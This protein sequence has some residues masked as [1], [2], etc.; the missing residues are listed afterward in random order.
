MCHALADQVVEQVRSKVALL[1]LTI[2]NRHLPKLP[3][4]ITLKD[5][6][7]EVRTWN[8]LKAAGFARRP[9][10]LS[11]KCIGEILRI[12]NFGAKSLVDLLTSLEASTPKTQAVP[13]GEPEAPNDGNSG[14]NLIAEAKRL[15][16]TNHSRLIH[17]ND[18]RLGEMVRAIDYGSET[19]YE[20]ADRLLSGQRIP[21]SAASVIAQLKELQEKIRAV[22]RIKLEAELASVTSGAAGNGRN[23]DIVARYF[24]WD[25]LG[26]TTLQAIGSEVGL[27]RERVRQICG[28]VARAIVR[29]KPFTPTLDRTLE[30]VASRL[31]A[32]ADEIERE[33]IVRE[34][35]RGPFRLEGLVK[36]AQLF[37]KETPFSV[38]KIGKLRVAAIPR[39]N[40][41]TTLTIRYARGSIASWGAMTVADVVARVAERTRSQISSETITSVL[42]SQ[43]DFRWLDEPSGWFWLASVPRNRLLNQ[44]RK[45]LSVSGRIG[46]SELREGVGRHYRTKGFAPP[47]RVLL[48]LCGQIPEYRLEGETVVASSQ[49]SW[50]RVVSKTEQ[51]MVKVLKEHGPI[52]RRSKL[53]ELCAGFGIKRSTFFTYL[54]N[55]PFLMKYGP[56][57]Y[58]LRGAEVSPDMVEPLIQR[59]RPSRVLLDYGWTLEG[60]IWLGYKLSEG[61]FKSGVFSIPA[62]MKNLTEGNFV[63]R[64]GDNSRVGTLISTK[65]RAWGLLPFFSRRGGEPGDHL[66]ILFD[67]KGR[68]A[69]ISIGDASLLEDLQGKGKVPGIGR[70]GILRVPPS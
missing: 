70:T 56:G 63:L 47:R 2:R 38:V 64:T 10:T 19:V 32:S 12:P 24:G 7:L 20:L 39:M 41:F 9:Q 4:D 69:V 18:P 50:E 62:A 51:I 43:A 5:L 42:S 65:G 22:S 59:R 3:D 15:R 67:L 48:A 27:T 35:T 57:V 25:G 45:I 14:P 21:I 26:G 58:G 6:E 61:M 1:P 29:R 30:F 33:L 28:R 53:E 49:L 60:K 16:K 44:I 66:V 52:M 46:V 37:G 55:A 13:R 54:D 68:E 31:P 34:F 11:D 36:V 8:C 17:R 40:E 23:K